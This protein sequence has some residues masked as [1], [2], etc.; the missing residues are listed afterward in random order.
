MTSARTLGPCLVLTLFA[1]PACVSTSPVPWP[2]RD[3]SCIEAH[4]TGSDLRA[5]WR[6]T[7]AG[8]EAQRD[9]VLRLVERSPWA[10][11]RFRHYRAMNVF[12]GV[13]GVGGLATNIG[14]YAAA[15]AAGRPALYVLSIAGLVIAGIGI[16]LAV[17][18][19]DP[20]REAVWQYNEQAARQG[21]CSW[22]T[23]VDSGSSSGD[24]HD[25]RR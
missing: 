10:H 18:N 8:R 3:G 14:G 17:T 19:E 20:F 5:Q 7:I 16:G 22:P 24:R 21:P 12:S 9:E 23:L 6:Y 13:L 11:E 15:G 4:L 2:P 25:D 1:L